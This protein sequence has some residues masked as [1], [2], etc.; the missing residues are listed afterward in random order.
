MKKK[1][2]ALN[3]QLQTYNGNLSKPPNTLK[4]Y[5]EYIEFFNEITEAMNGNKLENKKKDIEEM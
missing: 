4:E 2:D 1:S 3:K 5:C